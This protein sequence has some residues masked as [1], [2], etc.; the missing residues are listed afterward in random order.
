MSSYKFTVLTYLLVYLHPHHHRH[1]L[2]TFSYDIFIV[3]LHGAEELLGDDVLCHVIWIFIYLLT[4][5]MQILDNI[6]VEQLTPKCMQLMTVKEHHGLVLT[7]LTTW[8]P[9]LPPAGPR[10]LLFSVVRP[11]VCCFCL[12]ISAPSLGVC[13]CQ[14]VILSAFCLSVFHAHSSCF[15]FFVSRWNRA[16][17]APLVLHDPSTKRRCLTPKIYSP[18]FAQNRL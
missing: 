2:L 16:I 15:F 6:F 14:Q 3:R 13:Y 12:L 8:F 17:F 10:V 5:R 1:H 7:G 18:K 4:V 9:S 11:F